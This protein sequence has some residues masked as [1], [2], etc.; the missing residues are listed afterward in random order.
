ME[1]AAEQSDSAAL[2]VL[3]SVWSIYTVA[4]TEPPA[5]SSLPCYCIDGHK[6]G[7]DGESDGGIGVSPRRPTSFRSG[8]TAPALLSSISGS[9]LPSSVTFPLPLLLYFPM[10]SSITRVSN[11]RVLKFWLFFFFF[12]FCKVLKI[13]SLV[14][15]FPGEANLS[16]AVPKLRAC[17]PYIFL[18][19]RVSDI[20]IFESCIPCH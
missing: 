9:Q 4:K 13:T 8:P 5:P 18:L 16:Y 11:Q 14:S 12:F 15:L 20:I 7:R 6:R 19:M 3:E 17:S 2:L 1:R 10:I